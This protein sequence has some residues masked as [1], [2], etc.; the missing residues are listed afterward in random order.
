MAVGADEEIPTGTHEWLDQMPVPTLDERANFYLRAVHGEREFTDDEYS[1]ARGLLLDAMA[2]DIVARSNS[3]SPER[4]SPP[5]SFFANLE[6]EG[7]TA[8]AEPASMIPDS[9]PGYETAR[10]LRPAGESG[11]GEHPG[12]AR[13]ADEPEVAAALP[14]QSVRHSR[15]RSLYPTGRLPKRVAAACAG[16]ALATAVVLAMVPATWFVPS[17]PLQVAPTAASRAEASGRTATGV[18][19]GLM[20]EAEREVATAL[21]AVQL[22]A[23]E[24]SALLKHGQELIAQG[25][26]RLARLVLRQA[27]ESGSAPA[28]LA[29][30]RAY[31]PILRESSK[32]RP[33][34]PP[35]ITTARTWYQKAKDLGSTEAAHRLAQLPAA[36][37]A[38]ATRSDGR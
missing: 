13:V 28:A 31:D 22:P 20:A 2:A 35:D 26:L 3:P 16:A 5:T 7:L 23:D 17:N 33:D 18:D 19:A 8:F 37:P 34:V 12:T 9:Q 32:I 1:H 24:V 15:L 21:N 38:P 4:A 11:V 10:V 36:V 27:A 29:L 6:H 14:T 30:G 25:N